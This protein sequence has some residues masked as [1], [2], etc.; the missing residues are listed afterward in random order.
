MTMHDKVRMWF[1]FVPQRYQRLLLIGV[2]AVIVLT[3]GLI[4]YQWHVSN[5]Q[6][7]AQKSFLD[8]MDAY[9]QALTAML[10]VS[11][12]AKKQQKDLW[13]EAEVAF[14]VGY[15]QNKSSTLAPY[16]LALQADAFIYQEKQQEALGLLKQAVDLIP[17]SS[18]FSSWYRIKLAMLRIDQEDMRERGLQDLDQLANDKNNPF[19]DLAL[20]NLGAYYWARYEKDKARDV[21][22]QLVANFPLDGLQASGWAVRAKQTLEQF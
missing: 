3:G 8:C 2:L 6:S 14:K 10:N 13:Q 4:G 9:K 12:E 5:V 11:T 1:D 16:F 18:V 7:R 20:F 17:A 22:Q 15:D 21:W 19:R